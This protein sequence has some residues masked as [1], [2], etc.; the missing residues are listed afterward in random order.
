MPRLT[1]FETVYHVGQ[2]NG[3][4][5]K[6][7]FSYEGDGLCVSHHPED[8]RNIAENVSGTVHELHNPNGVFFDVDPGEL[9]RPEHRQWCLDNG[10]IRE[11][12]GYKV[13]R[14]DGSY[15]LFTDEEKA[16]TEA[17]EPG[18]KLE[19]MTTVALDTKGREYWTSAFTSNPDNAD[20][21]GVRGLLP[22]WY[23]QNALPVDVDGV[24]WQYD[25]SPASYSCPCGVIFQEKLAKWQ[26]REQNS[27]CEYSAVNC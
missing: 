10:Y 12:P 14:G 16:E 25:Y 17:W 21:L 11:V 20:P 19:E 23:A 5:E 1:A 6:P 26:S 22:V 2:L 15:S 4:R 27:G 8:W 9:P 13:I 18:N 24:W 3:K 7:Y